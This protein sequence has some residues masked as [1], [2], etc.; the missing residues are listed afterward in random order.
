M[1]YND[2]NPLAF[3]YHFKHSINMKHLSCF[4][5]AITIAAGIMAQSRHLVSPQ[6]NP[7]LYPVDLPVPDR[8]TS[9]TEV[10]Q[11]GN[12]L[13][14]GTVTTDAVTAIKIGESFNYF[15]F[16]LEENTQISA[17]SASDGDAVA[18]IYRQNVAA[19][20]GAPEENGK[21]RYSISTD[22]GLTW[23]VGAAGTS[24]A[25]T[26]PVGCYGL[27]PIN[28]SYTQV[29]NYPN[30]LL[31]QPGAGSTLSDLIGVYTGPVTDQASWDGIVAGVVTDPAGTPG[32]S[33]EDYFFQKKP[34]YQSYQLTERVAGEYWYVAW[35]YDP[36][37]TTQSPGDH[38]ELNKGVYDPV[39]QKVNWENVYTI[40]L[41]F[42]HYLPTGAIDSVAA[43]GTPLI[44]F[45]PDGMT[46]YVSLIG[47]IGDRDSVFQPI[48]IP[49]T[50]G[51]MTWEKPY[52]VDLKQFAELKD[53]LQSYWSVIDTTTGD[54][55]PAG[56]GIPSTA[57]SHDLVV[58]QY[59]HPHFV[60][61][62]T[63]SGF[64]NADGSSSEPNYAINS[65]LKMFVCDITT[66]NFGDPNVLIISPQATFRGY[67]DVSG[68]GTGPQLVIDPWMQASRTPD[69]SKVFFSWTESDTLG[70]F[71]DSDNSSPNFLTRGVDVTSLK[72]TSVVNHTIDDATWS[73]NA[74]MP[75]MAPIALDD[76]TGGYTLPSVITE[77][78]MTSINGG[79]ASFW[80]FSDV[81]YD[82]SDFT[83]DVAYFYTCKENPIVVT[84]AL[85]SPGCGLANGSI[86]LS[87]SGGTG[88]YV[89]QWD[90]TALSAVTPSVT[91]LS[92]G[93]YA[94]EVS[95]S[96]GCVGEAIFSLNDSN[97][98][99][100]VLDSVANISCYG[101]NDGY[102]S[103][104]A[105]GGTVSSYLWSNG[106]TTATATSLPGGIQTLVVT[107]SAGCQSWLSVEIQE[108]D[109][110]L[111]NLL[112]DDVSC[113]GEAD[114]C[115]FAY[116]CGGTGALSYVWGNGDSVPSLVG[117]PAGIYSLMVTDGNGC[118]DT[119]ATEV[120]QPDSLALSI[121]GQ[122]SM[123]CNP[124]TITA[125]YTGG[126][127]PIVF[128]WTGPNGVVG[129]SNILFG[130]LE[131]T[132]ILIA[133]DANGCIA[134][135][136]VSLPDCNTGV[137]GEFPAGI[138]SFTIHPNPTSGTFS[139][140][141]ELNHSQDANIEILTLQGQI[142]QQFEEHQIQNLHKELR[143]SDQAAGIY[144]L[145]V[146]TENGSASRK[147][148]VR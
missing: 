143:L 46:G 1:T 113:F 110:L 2:W 138:N 34:Q 23:D 66:D 119:T 86:T 25:G 13:P 41:A 120:V 37:A 50:D 7:L 9:T 90:S 137:E 114:G 30:L 131:G 32:F 130:L 105:T 61:I 109:S 15:S 17:V 51:G 136:S 48:L 89:Y 55:I 75:K 95:D 94:V 139:L 65:G 59:G 58:D 107:T 141:L 6:A 63:N 99:S 111:L 22:G 83:E 118:Q 53:S 116:V 101:A 103:V 112:I 19:C 70:N 68:T 74:L 33:Q 100:L 5:A 44:A 3:P 80:Y 125:N 85:L 126:T 88:S 4:L 10:T 115:A 121:S 29:S 133:E 148:I 122:M 144:F 98:V 146:T 72:A 45:S 24:S 140:T 123:P 134:M 47:D 142:V 104:T 52:E 129:T 76:G 81:T 71:G 31:S 49:T 84:A 40:P 106:E 27:G 93:V 54:T 91:G 42:V 77:L 79:P 56:N 97:A 82:A 73:A 57:F 128:T 117:V 124:T 14:I 147:V 35:N 21:Y 69:G 36:A 108:P 127:D 67:T 102:A 60:C 132:Y 92:S 20:G 38:L 28:A 26:T 64:N 43:R 78:N 12:D 18:F 11:P 145:Q 135:D 62:V 39:A 8:A 96:I 16:L 87:V